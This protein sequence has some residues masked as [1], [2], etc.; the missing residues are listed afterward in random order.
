MNSLDGVNGQC[1]FWMFWSLATTSEIALAV[2]LPNVFWSKTKGNVGDRSTWS[3]I[4]IAGRD[5]L[6]SRWSG[7]CGRQ[8]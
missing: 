7:S 6:K 1:G 8:P 3:G 5:S 2:Q 4:E